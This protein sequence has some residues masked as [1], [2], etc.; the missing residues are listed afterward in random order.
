[1]AGWNVEAMGQAGLSDSTIQ[2]ARPVAGSIARR[3]G[4]SEDEI[5]SL[6]GAAFLAMTLIDFIRTVIAVVK[7]GRSGVQR[8]GEPA[9]R[10]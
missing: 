8:P 1:M 7:A 4:R 6:L 2:V 10:R 9:A 5:L 3:T